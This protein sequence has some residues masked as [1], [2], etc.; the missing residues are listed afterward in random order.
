MISW[1]RSKAG[2]LF[3][4]SSL[5][6]NAG[7][8][9]TFGLRAYNRH[10]GGPFGSLPSWRKDAF[11]EQLNLRPDQL[12]QLQADGDTLHAQM[13]ELQKSLA[14]Q[15]AVLADLLV[16][17]Q[18]DREAIAMQLDKLAE[19]QRQK[20]QHVVEHFLHLSELLGSDQREVFEKTVRG[21]FARCGAG[22]G[23]FRGHHRTHPRGGPRWG[24]SGNYSDEE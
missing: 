17:A 8:G 19:M 12:A 6:F 18:P 3:L 20:Q 5:A 15:N 1:L 9:T 14:K 7:M 13:R 11:L 16:S 23:G 10:Y 2:C 22:H 24:G 4:I 21:V